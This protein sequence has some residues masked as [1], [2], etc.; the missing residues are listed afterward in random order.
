[1]RKRGGGLDFHVRNHGALS[2]G[3]KKAHERMTSRTSKNEGKGAKK[4]ARGAFFSEQQRK[5]KHMTSA[6]TKTGGV[7]FYI[8][9]IEP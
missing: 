7:G 2:E 6:L 8:A 4:T 9:V 1:M 3:K 5:K